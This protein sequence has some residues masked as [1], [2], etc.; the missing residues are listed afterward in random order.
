MPRRCTICDHPG[1]QDIDI[2]LMGPDPLR[3]IAQQAHVSTTALLRHKQHHLPALL[4]QATETENVARADEILANV[5]N[6]QRRTETILDIAEAAG[7]HRTALM[8]IRELRN[9]LELLAKLVGELQDGT[10][11]NIL[12]TPE[13]QVLQATIVRTL[14]PFPE[15]RIAVAQALRQL[16][17]AGQ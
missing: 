16:P 11:V 7:D 17:H 1:R 14:A 8:A 12:M 6:L 10:T 9:H 13:Y 2:Q 4:I 5:R 15:A 3:N